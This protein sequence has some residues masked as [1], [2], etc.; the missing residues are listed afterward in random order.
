MIVQL[1]FIDELGNFDELSQ[2]GVQLTLMPTSLQLLLTIDV[3][4]CSFSSKNML[5]TSILLR[6]RTCFGVPKVWYQ[7]MRNDSLQQQPTLVPN[8]Q[9]TLK[10]HKYFSISIGLSCCCNCEN[11]QPKQQLLCIPII[12][13]ILIWKEKSFQCWHSSTICQGAPNGKLL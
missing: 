8:E 13:A 5:K 2:N 3:N 12:F 9:R 10:I 11:V 6:P 7:E 1:F 4:T